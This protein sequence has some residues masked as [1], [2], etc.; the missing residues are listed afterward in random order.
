MRFRSCA[1][2]RYRWFAEWSSAVH[3]HVSR[4]QCRR[5]QRGHPETV[6]SLSSILPV[7]I[8][9]KHHEWRE[10][11][12]GLVKEPATSTRRTRPRRG[13]LPHKKQDLPA[14]PPTDE[15]SQGRVIFAG[16]PLRRERDCAPILSL[17]GRSL[18]S[19]GAV[20]SLNS[21]GGAT[22]L[23]Y[24]SLRRQNVPRSP[25]DWGRALADQDAHV[26]IA[27]VSASRINANICTRELRVEQVRAVTLPPRPSPRILVELLAHVLVTVGGIVTYAPGPVEKTGLIA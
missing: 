3:Q 2:A 26:A 19:V 21:S 17:A 13:G 23:P 24:V 9:I 25:H 12:K 5:R 15:A 10:L 7:G 14:H 27:N 11:E 6:I 8:G 18:R 1:P 20:H 22:R 16:S 4:Y